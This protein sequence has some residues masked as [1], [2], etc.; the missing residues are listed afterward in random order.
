[1]KKYLAIYGKPRYIGLVEYDGDIDK[2]AKIIVDSVRGEETAV[3]VGEVD[4][5]QEAEYRQ[6][7]NASEHGD[8]M[9][10]NSE[11]VVTDLKFLNFTTDEDED[12]I[13][14]YREEEKNI[15]KEAQRLLKPHN[16]DMKLI[17]V[18]FLRAKRKLF[19][20]FSSDQRVD[21]RAYVRDLARE[22]KTRIEL[23]QVGVRDEAKIIKGVGPCGQPCCCSYWLNQFAPIC[24]KMVK[25]Q[26]LALNPS[27]ISGICGRLMCCMCYE[28]DVYHEAW[29]G[30]PNP[31]AKIKTPNGS[32]VVTGIDLP[33]KSLRCYIPGRGEVAVP[34]EKFEEFKTVMANGGD[35]IVPDAEAAEPNA[36]IDDIFPKCMMQRG[37]GE[38]H[39]CACQNAEIR[40]SEPRA[41]KQPAAKKN[42]SQTQQQPQKNDEQGERQ[43]K[44]R[45]RRRPQKNDRRGEP[46]AQKNE[47]PRR[48]QPQQKKPQKEE[49]SQD[50]PRR[51]FQRRRRPTQQKSAAPEE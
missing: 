41:E 48:E 31:G 18:E 11:P 5:R 12:E 7:R 38:G 21:F 15:L 43:Q 6:L 46:Q 30:F 19:F 25:E 33:T 9:V 50:K 35:W 45:G 49:K 1:M 16:L 22:F 23:R 47:Q 27:K 14:D 13:D 36:K 3:V 51:S 37:N 40:K 17:D 34:K 28:Y 26:N 10:K 20:Y 2:G 8:G 39:R 29:E 32:V 42:D 44:K 24:I 4:D